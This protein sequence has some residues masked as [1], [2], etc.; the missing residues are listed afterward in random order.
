VLLPRP[1]NHPANSLLPML[2]LPNFVGIIP[3]YQ[4]LDI[5]SREIELTQYP[6]YV[7]IGQAFINVV[8]RKY[9][10]ASYQKIDN[11]EQNWNLWGY[12]LVKL[13]SEKQ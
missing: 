6:S 9:N 12:D 3:S 8:Y 11:Y 4:P 2:P 10:E 7:W 1:Q 5:R 13:I